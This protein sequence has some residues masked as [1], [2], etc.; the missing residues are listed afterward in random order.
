MKVL[1]PCLLLTILLTS[2]NAFTR[3][4]DRG[5]PWEYDAGAPKD[6]KWIDLFAETPNYRAFGK[7]VIGGR[8]EKFRWKMGPMWYR[9]RLTPQSVKVFIVGQEGAQD[10]NVSNR[11]FTGSTGTRMQKFLQYLGVDRSYLFMNTF[12]YTI[13]G[14]Y[15]LFGDDRTNEEKVK[16][17]ERLLW[18]AQSEDSVVVQHRHE[19][20]D[21]MLETNKGTLAV[22]IGVGSA[23]KDSVATWF[24]SHG[25]DC[26]SYYLSNRS[27]VGTGELEGVIAVGVR[28]PGS[29]SPRNGGQ[30]ARGGLV[31]DF[32]NKAEI[33]ANAIEAGQINLP[34]DQG[35]ERD[36]SENF[37]YGYASIPHRD[38]AWGTNWQMGRWA[39][40]SNRRGSQAI[41][42][43]SQ[44]GCYNNLQY[45]SE[46]EL[47][48]VFSSLESLNEN[49]SEA[50]Q[51][52][53]AHLHS[54]YQRRR[55]ST[56]TLEE[57]LAN[58][59]ER[60]ALRC[61]GQFP[62]V[63]GVSRSA[64]RRISAMLLKQLNYDEP[65]DL[66]GEAPSQMENGD[67]PYES[68]K[69]EE[70]RYEFDEGPSKY[71]ELMYDFFNQNYDELGVT[72]DL[73]FGH[74]GVY[75]GN[76][77]ET[78][79]VI[80]ADQASHTDMFSGR[81]LT[82]EAGQRLQSY[83][84]KIGLKKKYT[85]LRTLP[86]DTMDLTTERKIE[87]ANNSEVV[88]ARNLIVKK[89]EA[90]MQV[91]SVLLLGPVAQSLKSSLESVVDG[92]TKFNS[93]PLPKWESDE[94]KSEIL[95]EY[96]SKIRKIARNTI[97]LAS[98]FGMRVQKDWDGELTIIPRKDLPMHTRWW[99]GTSGDRATRAFEE[100]HGEKSYSGSYY[101]FLAPRWAERWD[102][103]EEDLND[104]ER[105][106]LA[107]FREVVEEID[108][109]ARERAQ[110][111]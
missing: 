62:R 45:K 19:L 12:V 56:Q 75:R 25:S 82:G 78:H 26:E 92:R 68:P 91:R 33:V 59:P 83:L 86:V 49:T 10:E 53:M 57:Y 14:Q 30:D 52:F 16:R 90:E 58:F 35:M 2:S 94:E 70:M 89:M 5:N 77:E 93:L 27:C 42:V 39:T 110:G 1:A 109:R 108:A 17:N 22:V 8:G 97:P 55:R 32:Q 44:E 80:I 69:G 74:T 79:L 20:F 54:E 28:H 13:T 60:N 18:L 98:A 3:E 23:G 6:S 48:E 95:S 84:E 29:A 81:A 51:L 106:S 66:L 102:V 38:F 15:S 85:I 64:G 96:N 11:S 107:S 87:I 24:K 104:S 50:F 67:V 111:R 34:V 41:Q 9:G 46:Q 88:A 73:D 105:L 43:F 63:N 71:A 40:T 36:I 65:S 103:S 72:Q 47:Q 31:G 21:Y 99:M 76:L 7:E 37:V 61:M 101:K 4:S 100:V